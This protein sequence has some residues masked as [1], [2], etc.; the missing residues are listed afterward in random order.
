M[1]WQKTKEEKAT[2]RPSEKDTEDEGQEL[3][4]PRVHYSDALVAPP[5]TSSSYRNSPLGKGFPS[6]NGASVAETT[7]EDEDFG[8]EDD[9]DWTGDEDII[10]RELKN[11]KDETTGA[12]KITKWSARRFIV[13]QLIVVEDLFYLIL[14]S[15]D[16]NILRLNFGR[17]YIPSRIT[18]H[19]PDSIESILVK[20][21]QYSIS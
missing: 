17:F 20:P 13:L 16:R 8:D 4:V 3:Q 21:K 19:R 6:P 1:R 18:C 12:V 10:D 7:D 9:Y 11:A 14:N 15:Q 5:A 2:K